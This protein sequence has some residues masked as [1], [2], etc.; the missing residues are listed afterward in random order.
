VQYDCGNGEELSQM[1]D[2]NSRLVSRHGFD[3]PKCDKKA[4]RLHNF[5]FKQVIAL[6]LNNTI[7][8]EA[9]HALLYKVYRELPTNIN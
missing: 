6:P 9:F 1:L 4:E 7:F 8:S 2:Q 3:L 5:T